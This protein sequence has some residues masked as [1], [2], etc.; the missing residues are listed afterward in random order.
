MRPAAFAE[1]IRVCRF[2]QCIGM[3]ALLIAL[4]CA[5][6]ALAQD[7]RDGLRHLQQ[8]AYARALAQFRPLAERGEADGQYFLGLMHERGYGLP[9]DDRKAAH[10]YRLAAKQGNASAQANLGFLYLEGHGVPRDLGRAF[11]LLGRAAREGHA[12][13]QFNLGNM[14]YEGK[15]IQQSYVLAYAWYRLSERNGLKGGFFGQLRAERHMTSEQ[16]AEARALVRQWAARYRR[17]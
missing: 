5:L 3:A 17:R 10:W 12:V 15:G 4:L 9:R 2:P 14:Y 16:I 7:Y 8:G 13:A 6:P 1:A 11:D